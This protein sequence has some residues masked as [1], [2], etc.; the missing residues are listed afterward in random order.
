MKNKVDMNIFVVIKYMYTS[1]R[2]KIHIFFYDH[3]LVNSLRLP[4]FA[5][6]HVGFESPPP[7]EML[8]KL[9]SKLI[10]ISKRFVLEGFT[11]NVSVMTQ[12]GFMIYKYLDIYIYSLYYC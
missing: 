3:K 4:C 1:S 8:E 12:C 10:A 11:V 7:A 2:Q 9:P 6:W 5:R